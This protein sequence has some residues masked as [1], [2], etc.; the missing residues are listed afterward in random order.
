MATK[1]TTKK[2]TAK[3]SASKKTQSRV[4]EHFRFG[5][6][7]TSLILGIVVV[8]IASILLISFVRNRGDIDIL[9]TDTPDI[10]STKIG[11]DSDQEDE[12]SYTVEEGDDLWTIAEKNYDSGY[13]WVDIQ[14]ANNIENPN[15]LAAGTKLVIPDVQPKTATVDS[16]QGS[17]AE[18][19]SVPASDQIT[20]SE[21]TVVEGD[22]LWRIAVRKYN[23]G[24]QYTRIAQVNNI[25][26]PNRILAGST[27]TLP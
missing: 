4:T 11:P 17:M 6:S 10:S 13:N 27:L 9:N 19:E 15:Q 14:E 25:A 22:T 5:E 1:K 21:Y 16:E 20:G 26:N 23:D 8:I 2:T 12:S 24:H 18:E 3:S 7:Y